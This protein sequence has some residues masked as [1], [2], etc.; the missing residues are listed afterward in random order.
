[1][2]LVLVQPETVLRWH[3]DWLRRRWTRR[4]TPRPVGRPPA[5]P[6]IRSVVRE[7]EAANPLWGAPRIH[8]E[9]RTLGIDVSERT[10]SRLLKRQPHS[11]SQ[12]WRTFLTNHLAS[13]AAMDFFTV[14]TLTGRILFVHENRRAGNLMQRD[15]LTRNARDADSA[16]DSPERSLA[17]RVLR[18]VTMGCWRA[19]RRPTVPPTAS[20]GRPRRTPAV[21]P[22]RHA[23]PA[24]GSLVMR[25]RIGAARGRCQSAYRDGSFG[26]SQ[27]SSLST[28]TRI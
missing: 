8:G 21:A 22:T 3:R 10:V 1:M 28:P 15:Q 5:E 24:R 19:R 25:V 2:A 20:I 7:M 11:P 26:H 14:P 27:I 16:A 17:R 4:S 13:A 9:L 12:T 23:P 6:E 18:T